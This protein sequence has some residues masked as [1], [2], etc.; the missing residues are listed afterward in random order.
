MGNIIVDGKVRALTPS[1]Q[2]DFD[3]MR[4]ALPSV[5]PTVPSVSKTQALIALQRTGKLAAVKTAVAQDP[6]NQIWFDSAQVWHRD[7]PRIE[8]LAPAVGLTSKD[9]DDLFALA[10]TITA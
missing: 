10:A 8:A 3:A 6:E 1:E 5:M 7:N 9:L 2:A 4:A